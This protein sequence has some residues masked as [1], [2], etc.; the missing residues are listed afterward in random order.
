[1]DV[2]LSPQIPVDRLST[3]DISEWTNH[4]RRSLLVSKRRDREL[5]F[6]FRIR[7]ASLQPADHGVVV[8]SHELR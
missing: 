8:L 2:C 4:R 5:T 3:R 6:R 7:R 1:M